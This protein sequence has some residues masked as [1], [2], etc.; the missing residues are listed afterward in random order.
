[1]NRIAQSMGMLLLATAPVFA[2]A[3]S[4]A[5]GSSGEALPVTL[6]LTASH[7][8]NICTTSCDS[9]LVVDFHHNGQKVSVVGEF[10]KR[11]AFHIG[12]YDIPLGDHQA[13]IVKAASA[14]APLALSQEVDI[15]L[16]DASLWKG[17]VLAIAE[18]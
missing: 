12:N 2:A 3:Q 7:L 6:H 1:M 5:T 15:V 18:Q 10:Y 13:R 14:T 9:Y 17:H 8:E 16:P 4:A 11:S